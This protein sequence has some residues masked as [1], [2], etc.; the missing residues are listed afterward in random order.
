MSKFILAFLVMVALAAGIERAN[1]GD[2][3]A[4]LGAGY[5][6]SFFAADPMYEWESGGS[7]GFYG[8]IRY[9]TMLVPNQLGVVLHY[10]HH[11]NW[12]TGPPFNDN[13]ESSLDHI[14][15]AVRWRLNR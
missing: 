7:P 2:W 12:F 9:E 15:I 3:Y 6:G 14:G 4:E 8:S 11:S 13:V 10:T 1:A 5:S